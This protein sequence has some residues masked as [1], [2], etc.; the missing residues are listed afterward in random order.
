MFF[1]TASLALLHAFTIFY[2][3]TRP[4]FVEQSYY[5][6]LTVVTWVNGINYTFPEVQKQ[7]V[8]LSNIFGCEVRPFYNPTTGSIYG[9]I[10]RATYFHLRRPME[11]PIVIELAD[12][13]KIILDEIG[14]RYACP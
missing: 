11:N 6:P 8:E 9:D 13:L 2:F 14:P 10:S 4:L 12:H 5:N 7:A 1:I 3:S